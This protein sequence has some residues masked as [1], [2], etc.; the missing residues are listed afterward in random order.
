MPKSRRSKLINLSQ[1]KKKTKENKLI[2]LN[3]VKK[4]L[5]EFKYFFIL[6]LDGIKTNT[7]QELRKTWSE[8]RIVIGKKKLLKMAII[9]DKEKDYLKNVSKLEH[10]F[11]LLLGIFF[12]NDDVESVIS[13]FSNFNKLEYAKPNS[14]SRTDFTI[15]K[16]I[17][18]SRGG[19]IP[20]EN[21]LPLSH[22]LE[23]F[24]RNEL[25]IPVKLK[26]GKIVLENDYVVC[27]KKDVLTL[28]QTNILKQFGIATTPFKIDILSY[29]DLSRNIA[30]LMT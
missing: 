13:Y 11:G 6:R 18:Y 17:V 1:V 20:I 4:L 5:N 29:Y 12:T 26:S 9:F 28:N 10:L 24:L 2:L 3:K 21:D 27:K 16:G 7:L 30:F 22:S 14:V 19:Q 8:S 15:P 25:K 23:P